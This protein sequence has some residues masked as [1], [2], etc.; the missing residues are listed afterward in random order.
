MTTMKRTAAVGQ[1]LRPRRNDWHHRPPS[2]SSSSIP[3]LLL[4]SRTSAPSFLP[5]SSWSPSTSHSPSRLRSSPVDGSWYSTKNG[6]SSPPLPPAPPDA[7]AKR[8]PSPPPPPPRQHDD[9]D[10][11]DTD[12]PRFD[13]PPV[14]FFAVVVVAP[15]PIPLSLPPAESSI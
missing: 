6:T 5:S 7:S 12:I 3:F 8:R 2:P 14:V 9:D 4:L 11:C 1:R 15:L 10:G 13:Y